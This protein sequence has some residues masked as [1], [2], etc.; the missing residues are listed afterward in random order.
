MCSI[1]V[2]PGPG[3]GTTALEYQS[4]MLVQ[5]PDSEGQTMHLRKFDRYQDF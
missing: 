5:N 4:I 1:G 3:L 2:P